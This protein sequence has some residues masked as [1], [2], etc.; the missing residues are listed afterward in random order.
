MTELHRPLV[1]LDILD[2]DLFLRAGLGTAHV[3]EGY[4][5]VRRARASARAVN[6]IAAFDVQRRAPQDPAIVGV[7]TGGVGD[8]LTVL[9]L[10]M[11]LDL[12]PRW[13]RLRPRV[14]SGAC[15]TRDISGA[16]AIR[17]INGGC[18]V[19]VIS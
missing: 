11:P 3:C 14:I 5:C 1:A 12:P 10:A 8:G 18:A 15:A 17:V 9:R 13:R 6:Q 16:C 19:R 7:R 2:D 4:R